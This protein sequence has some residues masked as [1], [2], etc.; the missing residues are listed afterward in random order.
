MGRS[1]ELPEI[2]NG[3]EEPE[4]AEAREITRKWYNDASFEG[5]TS[6]EFNALREQ[7]RKSNT[8]DFAKY[9]TDD[10]YRRLIH[11]NPLLREFVD[12]EA[13]ITILNI[14]DHRD[15]IE[16]SAQQFEKLLRIFGDSIREKFHEQLHTGEMI[17]DAYRQFPPE[18]IAKHQKELLATLKREIGLQE[19]NIPHSPLKPSPFPEKRDPD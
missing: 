13:L 15:E 17:K 1:P 11:E 7:L 16:L 5:R 4:D 12:E 18:K 3:L 10:D 8:L 9:R 14:Y 2:N 6:S 19:Q